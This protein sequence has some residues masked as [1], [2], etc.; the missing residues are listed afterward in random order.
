MVLGG[1]AIMVEVKGQTSSVSQLK[2]EKGEY[3]DT[4]LGVSSASG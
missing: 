2:S 3:G 4:L 1:L